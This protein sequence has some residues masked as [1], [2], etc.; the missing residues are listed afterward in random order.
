MTSIKTFYDS[1]HFT[2][3]VCAARITMTN[4]TLPTDFCQKFWR[5]TPL[6]LTTTV[7]NVKRFI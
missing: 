3:W 5:A 6:F 7:F 4:I 2:A 1:D